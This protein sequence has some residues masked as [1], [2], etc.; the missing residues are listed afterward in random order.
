VS[1][2]CKLSKL[3]IDLVGPT[4]YKINNKHTTLL[5]ACN[6]LKS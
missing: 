6:Y 3:Q 1:H 4:E 2:L 5:N